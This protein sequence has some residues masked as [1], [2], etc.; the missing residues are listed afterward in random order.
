VKHAWLGAALALQSACS[1]LI[2]V[3]DGEGDPSLGGSSNEPDASSA[4]SGGASGAGPA[5]AGGS[6]PNGGSA[7]LEGVAGAGGPVATESDA[8]LLGPD[9]GLDGDGGGRLPT[10]PTFDLAF[11]E[12]PEET[13]ATLHLVST[14]LALA[15]SQS[16]RDAEWKLTLRPADQAGDVLDFA[17]SPDGQR[18]AA[19]YTTLRGPELAIF[20]APDWKELPRTE[21]GSPATLPDL[22][23]TANYR[24][25]PD[26]EALALELGGGDGPMVGGYVIDGDGAFGLPPVAFAGPIETMDWRSATSLYVTQPQ[27]D[28]P[29]LIELQLSQRAFE[30]PQSVFAIGL[31]FPLDLRHVPGGV[32]AASDDP[33]NFLFFWPESPEEGIEAAFLPSSYLSAGQSFVSEGEDT[34]EAFV[35][36]IGNSASFVQAVPDCPTVLAW[37]D[38]PDRRSLA[39][40]KLACLALDDTSA[41]ITIHAYDANAV[42]QSTLLDDPTLSADFVSTDS[43][44]A[45]ARG[46]SSNGQLLALASETRDIWIDL[47][48]PS[49][50]VQISE[51]TA[52][53]NTAR[54]FSP[55]GQALLQQRGRSIEFVVVP[56][57]PGA[58]PERYTLPDA[59]VDL[60]PCLTAHHTLDWCGAPSAARRAAA[61]WS[62]RGDVAA[63]LAA[64][65]G[66]SVLAKAD[67]PP[68]IRRVPVSTCGASCVTQ[69]E[70]GR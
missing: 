51:G 41:R 64:D 27:D 10:P 12:D 35:Y 42:R 16:D 53:G 1:L 29:E 26:G 14:S 68:S 48:G 46:F 30:P 33:L 70:F 5:G 65:D 47:R 61:R 20:A 24:W 19:R 28:E 69:Y 37:A 36:R 31:F 57:A 2:E 38:G 63:L 39:E 8:G 4:A 22:E 56:A 17:W 9:A 52:Q 6:A 7:G 67:Q 45:H 25:S 32:I 34:P 55:S 59:S 58:S 23:A 40:S 18:I 13:E 44:E 49:P 50:V 43:W 62:S 60:P 54:G 21:S 11:I 15:P 3:D 66:L